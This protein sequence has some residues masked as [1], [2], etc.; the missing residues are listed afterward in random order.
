MKIVYGETYALLESA[1]AG[2]ITSGTATLEGALFD[3]PQAVLYRTSALGYRIVKPLIKINFISLVN[4]IY[5]KQLVV[6]IIQNDLYGRTRTE[7][8]RI[9]E[10]ADY[11][12]GMKKGYQA[13][14]SE[15]KEEGVSERI[16]QRMIEL[17]KE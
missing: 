13:I 6:E 17:L 14:R 8:S 4:L 12:E 7:L 5:G 15:L 2:L 9:L 16:S 10:D 1:F 3:L 11:R